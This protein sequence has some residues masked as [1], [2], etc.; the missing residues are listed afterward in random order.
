MATRSG[1]DGDDVGLAILGV[2]LGIGGIA[3]AV[4]QQ[5]KRQREQEMFRQKMQALR[6]E[7][8]QKEARLT[9]LEGLLGPKNEQVRILAQEVLR[10]RALLVANNG[11][12]QVA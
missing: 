5:T 10:L 11:W 12:S 2:L 3:L 4:D 1:R 9:A 7:L 6:A 8:D